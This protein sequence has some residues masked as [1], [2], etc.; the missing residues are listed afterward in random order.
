MLAYGCPGNRAACS[1]GAKK[2]GHLVG[3]VNVPKTSREVPFALQIDDS[4]VVNVQ[5][6]VGEGRTHARV[7]K[8]TDGEED[9]IFN[10]GKIRLTRALV[11]T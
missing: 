10:V 2:N 3:Q 8:L 7:T 4:D 6:S 11:R 9:A 1:D 5:R